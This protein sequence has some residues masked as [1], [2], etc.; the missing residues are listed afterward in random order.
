MSRFV[1]RK[2]IYIGFFLVLLLGVINTVYML[3]K[4]MDTTY[5]YVYGMIGGLEGLYV[6]FSFLIFFTIYSEDYKSMT[7]I[8]V[9]GKGYP[10]MKLVFAKFLAVVVSSFA[11]TLFYGIITLLFALALGQH[12][13]PEEVMFYV[14]TSAKAF[15]TM[16]GMITF[17]S[18]GIY[19]TGST[20]FS[21]LILTV[22]LFANEQFSSLLT[23]TPVIKTLHLERLLF[24]NILESGGADV[25]IGNVTGGI[26][27]MFGGLI[28]YVALALALIYLFFEKKEL[29]F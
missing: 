9:I 18:V 6:V 24:Q 15:L 22:V 10:R 25:M 8:T 27:G 1:R 2:K 21:F 7:L 16:I 12:P 14:V 26:G 19:A 23:I 28:V 29:D 11:L 17:A 4:Y 20:A 13:L 5:N 3:Y